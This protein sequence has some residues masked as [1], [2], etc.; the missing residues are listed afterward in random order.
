MISVRVRKRRLENLNHYGKIAIKVILFLLL[1]TFAFSSLTHLKNHFPIKF[2]RVVGAQHLDSRAVQQ[3]LTPLVNKNFFSID[4]E[5]IKDRL[6]QS[7]W[8]A[9]A[10]VQ[11]VWPDKVFITVVE[12]KP[13]ARWNYGSLLSQNGEIFSPP[14]QSYPSHIPLF[15]GPEGEHLQMLQHYQKLNRLLTSLHL[16]IAK[17]E[18]IPQVAWGVTFDNGMKLNVG[19]KDVLT[20]MSHFVKVYHKIIGNRVADVEYVDLRYHNGLAVRWK[21][22][23]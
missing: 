14:A 15:V 16:K 17:L 22:V 11:R 7:P 19:Y 5:L 8:V 18:M 20:R 23:T 2:V 4:V 1:I 3:A 21:T 9:N 12:K 13:V 10:I 6:I